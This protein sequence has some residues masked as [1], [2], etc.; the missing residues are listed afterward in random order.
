[1][2][3]YTLHHDIIT[4]STH[5]HL[6][7]SCQ[8]CTSMQEITPH[9]HLSAHVHQFASLPCLRTHTQHLGDESRIVTEKQ[10]H[11]HLTYN[12]STVVLSH[13]PR[14]RQ[15]QRPTSK[16]LPARCVGRGLKTPNSLRPQTTIRTVCPRIH[17]PATRTLPDCYQPPQSLV[18]VGAVEGITRSSRDFTTGATHLIRR[19]SCRLNNNKE[20]RRCCR[21]TTDACG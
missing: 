11:G 4:K 18:A 12:R 3:T 5:T 10:L 14:S 19:S 1:M 20:S 9:T 8:Q 13:L 2:S 21:V 6:T 15:H 16:M 7:Q 17:Q